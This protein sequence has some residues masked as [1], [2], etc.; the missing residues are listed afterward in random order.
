M[1][2][3][4]IELPD[5]VFSTLGKEPDELAREMKIAAAVKWYELGEISQGKA[6]EIAGLNR[7][8]FM[9]I[10]IRYKVSPFQYTAEELAEEIA[11]L[12]E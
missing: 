11:S 3:L 4:S 1:T 9:N 5:S 10:L 12:D 8:E 2:T 7:I 6:A